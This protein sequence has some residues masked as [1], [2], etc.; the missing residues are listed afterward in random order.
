MEMPFV[1]RLQADH[2]S[3]LA[4]VGTMGADD[5]D[6]LQV[7]VLDIISQGFTDFLASALLTLFAGADI[8]DFRW[9]VLVFA[10]RW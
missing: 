7:M 9:N 4:I 6:A 10:H 5:V 3:M 1:G 8:K 2:W